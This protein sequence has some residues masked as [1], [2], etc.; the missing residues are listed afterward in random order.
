MVIEPPGGF[1]I[2]PYIIKSFLFPY[3]FVVYFIIYI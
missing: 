1:I 3:A 2:S